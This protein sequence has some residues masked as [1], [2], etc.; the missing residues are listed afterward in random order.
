MLDDGEAQ[1]RGRL[2]E[3]VRQ[4]RQAAGEGAALHVLDVDPESRI[5]ERRSV[6]APFPDP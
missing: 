2:A 1:R 4:A 5:P 6:L 3:A